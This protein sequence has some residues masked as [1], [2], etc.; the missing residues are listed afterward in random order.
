MT[1]V[2]YPLAVITLPRLTRLLSRL[3]KMS[4]T[5]SR[6]APH[7][8]PGQRL[9][10]R[11]HERSDV[12]SNFATDAQRAL[13]DPPGH[14]IQRPRMENRPAAVIRNIREH[15]M[16]GD[17]P[18]RTTGAARNRTNW[19]ARQRDDRPGSGRAL[20]RQRDRATRDAGRDQSDR[21]GGGSRTLEIGQARAP[22]VELIAT[23]GAAEL[24]HEQAV[25]VCWNALVRLAPGDV[26]SCNRAL[27][28]QYR[29]RGLAAC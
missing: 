20:R 2:G 10:S 18:C 9:R 25:G 1:P 23:L 12:D 22:A 17:Q 14:R 13:L 3:L 4:P 15:H 6:H 27:E 28:K 5:S 26:G 19:K 7:R 11:R 29:R 21:Q 16:A 8:R 24:G